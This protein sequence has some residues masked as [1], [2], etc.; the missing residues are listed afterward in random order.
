MPGD[1][2]L[3]PIT[4]DDP[5][6]YER[7]G[8]PHDQLAW[9]RVHAPVYW[10]PPGFGDG[11][12]GFWAITKHADIEYISRHPETFSSERRLAVFYELANEDIVSQRHMLLHMD[13]PRHTRLRG[14]VNRGFTPR[15]IGR[16]EK[17]I[18]EVCNDLLDGVTPRGEADFVRDIAA[19]LPLYVICE[20]LGAPVGDRHDLFR[21]ASV[22]RGADDPVAQP[23]G[24]PRAAGVEMYRY[25]HELVA[26]RRAEPQDDI[27]TQLLSND[28]NGAA[29]TADEIDMFVVLLIIAG[30]ETTRNAASGGMLAFFEH[31]DQWQRLLGDRTLAA[32][33]AE[34]IVRWT[35]PVNQFRRTATC[36]TEI[37][38]QR[39]AEGD[40][41]V[42]FYSSANRDEEVFTDPFRFDIGRDP[43]PHLGYGGGGPHF[44]LGRHLAALELRVLLDTLRGR[45]PGIQAAG[46]AT[47][48]PSMFTPGIRQLPVR[49]PPSPARR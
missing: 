24:D 43:N 29:L 26:R 7:R 37:R 19:P 38:G 25:I 30:S 35:S 41:V 45:I 13:P 4:L 47:R 36:D 3:P 49:F 46:E 42:V 28:G 40:K 27:L 12:P 18:R 21:L 11:W 17:H 20:L 2:T 8:I 16:L 22:S 15:L 9:L 34:E 48:L 1:R 14:L 44:C 5:G 33:A 10:H 31:P 23:Q 32:T 39:I 6:V